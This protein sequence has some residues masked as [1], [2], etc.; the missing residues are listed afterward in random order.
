MISKKKITELLEN[1]IKNANED[2]DSAT[3]LLKDVSTYI[4]QGNE[5]NK[6]NRF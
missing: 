4:C 1:T 6:L 3:F 2:R 5:S